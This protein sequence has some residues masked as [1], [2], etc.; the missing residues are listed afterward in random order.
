MV[1]KLRKV[2]KV[3][4]LD[5][6]KI[7]NRLD[8]RELATTCDIST[9]NVSQK[10]QPCLINF[11]LFEHLPLLPALDRLLGGSDID[12]NRWF[13]SSDW[14]FEYMKDR[15]QMRKFGEQM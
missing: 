3:L 2:H 11:K 13:R 4:G 10:M 9:D 12:G 15:G 14:T 1:F 8:N 5:F 6:V 7:S